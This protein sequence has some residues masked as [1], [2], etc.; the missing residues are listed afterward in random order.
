MS[1]GKKASVWFEL[2]LEVGEGVSFTV[3]YLGNSF[4]DRGNSKLK[5]PEMGVC[6]AFGNSEEVIVTGSGTSE[7][8]SG[9]E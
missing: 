8:V 3:S 4:P 1:I 6:L 7:E 5:G 2:R 9:K